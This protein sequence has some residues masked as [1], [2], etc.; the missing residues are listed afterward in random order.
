MMLKHTLSEACLLWF[1]KSERLLLAAGRK[2]SA[3]CIFVALSVLH[4]NL[5]K[6]IAYPTKFAAQY[7]DIIIHA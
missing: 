2:A 5:G 4:T 7:R 3:L 6:C 1:G